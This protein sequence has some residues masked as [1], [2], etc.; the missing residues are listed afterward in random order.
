[1]ATDIKPEAI[2][3]IEDKYVIIQDQTV[4]H[5]KLNNMV[6]AINMMAEKNWRCVNIT[7]TQATGGFAPI[8]MFAL[9]AHSEA[10][11]ALS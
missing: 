2:D 6:E 8:Y 7:S 3:P 4:I 9:I 10:I 11:P 5:S 1:M